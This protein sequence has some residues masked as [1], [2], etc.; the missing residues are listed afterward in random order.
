MSI[1]AALL[2]RNLSSVS[3]R[4]FAKNRENFSQKYAQKITG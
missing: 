3:E 1:E 4:T 2:P